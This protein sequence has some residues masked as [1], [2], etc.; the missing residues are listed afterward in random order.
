MEAIK[1]VGSPVDPM[2][3]PVNQA[4][5]KAVE[6]TMAFETDLMK[7]GVEANVN[8]AETEGAAPSVSQVFNAWA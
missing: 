1:G 8:G 3:H 5:S 4:M 6:Q 7:A 2:Q